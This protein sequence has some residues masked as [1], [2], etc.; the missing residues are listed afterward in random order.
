MARLEMQAGLLRED[1]REVAEHSE[2]DAGD[3][4]ADRE[5]DPRH[6]A[7]D[8]HSRLAAWAGVRPRTGNTAH[9]HG[10][11]DLEDVEADRPDDEGRDGAGDEA[12]DEYL[13]RDRSCELSEKSCTGIDADN[14]DE[15]NEAQVF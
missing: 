14:G 5:A 4:V 2:H 3:G 9:Q 7:L 15:N 8:F 13:Q 10:R 6:A 12:G 11:I 1:H